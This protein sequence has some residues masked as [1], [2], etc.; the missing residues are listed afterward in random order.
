LEWEAAA[1]KA[2]AAR[3]A[4]EEAREKKRLAR[5][6]KISREQ[7]VSVYPSLLLGDGALE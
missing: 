5:V 1:K 4:A 2:A 7:G 3:E 6:A